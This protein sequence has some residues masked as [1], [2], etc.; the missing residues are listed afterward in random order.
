MEY[1]EALEYLLNIL[2]NKSSYSVDDDWEFLFTANIPHTNAENDKYKIKRR[3][4]TMRKPQYR[5]K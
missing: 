3:K 1:K 4:H 5:F 2:A